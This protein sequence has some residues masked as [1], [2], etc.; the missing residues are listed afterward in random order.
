MKLT[1]KTKIN[2]III[3]DKKNPNVA[4]SQDLNMT[5]LEWTFRFSMSNP[6]FRLPN[7]LQYELKY[8]LDGSNE[9]TKMSC[10]DYEDKNYTIFV[11]VIENNLEE[12]YEDLPF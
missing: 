9:F 1:Q 8:K 5:L 12:Q 7:L 3:I 10:Y 4:M 11:S 6:P 2:A